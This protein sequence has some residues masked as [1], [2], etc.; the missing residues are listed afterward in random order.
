MSA[1]F[2]KMPALVR[3]VAPALSLLDFPFG[4]SLLAVFPRED[5]R[6]IL[7]D[8]LLTRIAENFFGP[9]IPSRNL[10]LGID[11]KNG[12]ILG[13]IDQHSEPLIG[14]RQCVLRLGLLLSDGALGFSKGLRIH[15]V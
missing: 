6:K 9:S 5:R 15:L 2:A 3:A 13:R 1:I 11:R 10:S 8:N 14:L 4:S 7:A 12:V